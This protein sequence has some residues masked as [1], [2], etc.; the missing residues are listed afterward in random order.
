VKVLGS[1]SNCPVD[2]S[3]CY[4]QKYLNEGPIKVVD[5]ID[6]LMREVRSNIEREPHRLFR[7]G[8]WE[9]GDSLALEEKSGQ[10][11]GLIR[12]FSELENAIL[13]LKTKSD[14]VDTI[15][16]IDHR[17][18]TVVSWSLN[19]EYVIDHEEHGT[20]TLERRI[21][22]MSRVADAGYLVG[23]HFDP[24]ILHDGWE[25]GYKRLLSMVFE[26]VPP[27][28]FAWISMG[29]LRFNPE[30][31]KMMENNFPESRLTSAEMV[32]GDDNKVRYVKPLRIGM[33]KHLYNELRRYTGPECLI[34]LCME[35]WDVWDRV[36][37]FCPD[38]PEHLDYLFAESLY[39]RY[40]LTAEPPLR[41]F[42]E[43]G[44]NQL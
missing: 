26:A 44:G 38:S 16:D 35:R 23:A 19:T 10:A 4:L 2:C 43:S 24:M 27:E 30:M 22:A 15:L 31:K 32:P 12:G 7:I 18:R 17:Q 20:A 1:V 37:G 25:D 14:S 3:C 40:G 21:E 41:K 36:M 8:T 11:A 5:D 39:K 9:L 33:Y 6:A 29:S 42:Y 28:R 34:Y 13:E